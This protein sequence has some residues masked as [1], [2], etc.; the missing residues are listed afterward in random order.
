MTWDE[1][2]GGAGG[3]LSFEAADVLAAVAE[4]GDLFADAHPAPGA[5]RTGPRR[6]AERCAAE[7]SA[8]ARAAQGAQ[9]SRP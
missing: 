8:T 2:A 9:R 4:H 5:A 1:V 6:G 3:P 7:E